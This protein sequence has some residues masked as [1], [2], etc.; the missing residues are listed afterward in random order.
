[1]LEQ[2]YIEQFNGH[3]VPEALL[4]LLQ[5]ANEKS[6]MDCFSDGFEFSINL[7]KC[8]LKTYSENEEFLSSII[9]FANADSTGSTYG[10]WLKNRDENLIEAPVVIF[11]SEGGFHVVA[12]NINGLLQIL[13][14]DS[15]PLV[16]WDSLYYYKD[17]DDYEPSAKIESYR[18]WLKNTR[19][20][21]TITNADALVELAQKYHRKEFKD[22][23]AKFYQD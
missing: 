22:W 2:E 16:D 17:P 11:G 23:M 1:M 4:S 19:S 7:D 5:F 12:N 6:K 10:F 14:F 15:E 13:T 9:E 3:D 20:L 8:G 18:S 21:E